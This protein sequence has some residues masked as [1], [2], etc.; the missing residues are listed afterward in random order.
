MNQDLLGWHLLPGELWDRSL[1]GAGFFRRTGRTTATVAAGKSICLMF[2]N[3][4]LRTRTS[5]ELAAVELGAHVTTVTPGSGVWSMAFDDGAGMDGA[6]AEHVREAAGVLSRYYD[7]IGVRLFASL[8]DLAQDRSDHLLS[9]FAAA[10]KVPVVNLESAFWHPCQ[11]LAD[12]ATIREHLQGETKG[13][14]L[15]LL[16]SYHPKALPMAV[17]N[18]AIMMAVRL[19]MDVTVGRP[20]GFGLDPSVMQLARDEAS[21]RGGSIRETEDRIEALEGSDI[22]YSKAWAGSS[23]YS[24]ADEEA[25]RRGEHT[26]WRVTSADMARTNHGAFMHCLPVRRNVVVDDDVLDG[27]QAIHLL[28]AEYRL[29]AQKAILEMIWELDRGE[30]RYG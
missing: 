26:T 29:H 21:R 18:S 9:R 1:S 19:G 4:S 2:F 23:V 24:N 10:A 25:K 27:P 8:S 22:V 15:A 17:P 28:Q 30:Q 16:W 20:E 6:E 7:A 3:S 11:E 14:K 12:A 5:M 13:R